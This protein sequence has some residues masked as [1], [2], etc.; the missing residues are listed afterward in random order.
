MRRLHHALD[1][2]DRA[3]VVAV[4]AVRMMQVAID[5]IIDVV[6]MRHG[7]MTARRA[8]N[9][10]RLMAS[11]CNG[12]VIWYIA[13]PDSTVRRTVPGGRDRSMCG[14]RRVSSTIRSL[15]FSATG[16][17]GGMGV[18]DF[19]R[20]ALPYDANRLLERVKVQK[21]A[22][23]HSNLTGM[24]I[25]VLDFL[26]PSRDLVAG[27]LPVSPYFVIQQFELP[28]ADEQLLFQ[29][30]RNHTRQRLQQA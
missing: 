24:R 8:V 5:E 26:V 10:A 19:R 17:G 13:F 3:V 9:V 11:M 1:Q 7:F 22:L 21:I 20:N 4:I 2:F 18:F 27:W 12:W 29:M 14:A 16:S 25:D 6:P 30:G 28:I 15:F 23:W